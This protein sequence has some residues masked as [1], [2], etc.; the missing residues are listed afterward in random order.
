MFTKFKKQYKYIFLDPQA[1]VPYAHAKNG[2]SL[3]G[4]NSNEKINIILAPSLYWV[5]KVSLPLKNVRDVKKLLPS[6]FED[7]LPFGNYSYS[8]YKSGS[9]FFI[10]AYEDRQILGT[11]SKN[12]IPISSIA[13][14]YFAQSVLGHIENAMKINPSQCIYVKDEILLVVPSSW[15]EESS[16]LDLSKAKASKH[17]ITLQQ[18][19]HIVDSK[20]LYKIGVIMFILSLLLGTE[21]FITAHKLQEIT[22]LKDELFVKYNLQ[23]TLLQNNSLLKKYDTL[24]TKQ[25]KL[26]DTISYILALKLNPSEELSQLKF[27]NNVL[28]AKFN[29]IVEGKELQITQSLK[30]K[31]I[32][33]KSSFKDKSWHVEISI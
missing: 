25:M 2:L 5:K 15:A 9:E 24:H 33:F 26:R 13:N 16:P 4:A 28:E 10:F 30:D 29:G 32:E 1:E 18:F 8:A 11:L 3:L 7:T 17:S 20:S 22:T 21:Y 31:K 14:V 23:P 19:G 6:L 12:N 27:K